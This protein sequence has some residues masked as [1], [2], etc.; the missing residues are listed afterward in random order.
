MSN[1]IPNCF[2]TYNCGAGDYDFYATWGDL[3]I[4][5]N[6]LRSIKIVLDFYNQLDG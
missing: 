1:F 5:R 3:T 2:W 6:Y 4:Q